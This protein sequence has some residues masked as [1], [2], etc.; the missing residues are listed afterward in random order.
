LDTDTEDHEQTIEEK[1]WAIA[2]VLPLLHAHH[3]L[4]GRVRVSCLER[5]VRATRYVPRRETDWNNNDGECGW[6]T[7]AE[8]YRNRYRLDEVAYALEGLQDSG[9]PQ[10][11]LMLSSLYYTYI[12]PFD[13]YLPD[14]ERSRYARAGLRCLAVGIPGNV[15]PYDPPLA[16]HRR[17]KERDRAIGRMLEAGLAA[18]AIARLLHCST[19][20][21]QAVKEGKVIKHGMV[22]TATRADN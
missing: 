1:E 20:T 3:D 18:R 6:V 17:R 11:M 12:E 21:I 4:I 13:R 16:P 22:V 19:A 5:V 14:E 15:P 7:L 9:H 10:A 2:S 8:R